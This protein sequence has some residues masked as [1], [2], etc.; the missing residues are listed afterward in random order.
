LFAC[1][2]AKPL[3]DEIEVIVVNP[4]RGKV[5]RDPQSED[6]LAG[7]EANDGLKPKF[8]DVFGKKAFEV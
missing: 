7:F 2:E 6:V 5:V 4:D 3:N 1:A 8:E